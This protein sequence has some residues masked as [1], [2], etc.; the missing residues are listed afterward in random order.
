MGINNDPEKG[1]INFV[2]QLGFTD[3]YLCK[4]AAGLIVRGLAKYRDVVQQDRF[5]LSVVRQAPLDTTYM[6]NI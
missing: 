4:Q 5:W 1:K 3:E 2:P 6:H